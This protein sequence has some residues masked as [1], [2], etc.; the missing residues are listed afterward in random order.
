VPRTPSSFARMSAIA[1]RP[2]GTRSI[3]WRASPERTRLHSFA[4]RDECR[5]P[6]RLRRA[7]HVE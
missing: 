3:R 5:I 1:Y 4:G 2:V 7:D 6:G